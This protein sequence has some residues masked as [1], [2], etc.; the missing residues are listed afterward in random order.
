MTS[1]KK[2]IGLLSGIALG[3]SSI[4]GSGWLFA[5]YQAATIAGPAAIFSWII[6]SIIVSLLGL[7][8]A[9]I[10][11]L[12]PQRGL[13]A[14]IPI[15]SHNRHFAFPFAI[16]NWLGVVA[17]I[18]LE[19]DATNEYLINLVPHLQPYL[20]HA[21]HLTLLGNLFS[22]ALVVLFGVFNYWGA[23]TLVKANNLLTIVKV[24]VPLFIGCAILW[25]SFNPHNF[26]AVKNTMAPYG[27]QS[28]L[29]AILTCGIVVSFNGFQGIVSFA[30]DIKSP[31][32]TIPQAI[33]LSIFFSLL[34]YLVLEFA[35]IGAIPSEA[36]EHGWHALHFYAPVIQVMGFIGLGFLT[37][38]A[39]FGATAAPVGCGI[40]FTGTASRMFTAMA[41]HKQMPSYFGQIHPVYAISRRSLWLNL[42]LSIVFILL[43]N[44]WKN[45]AEVLGLLHV[46]S[47]L[48][49][50]IALW[51]LRSKICD[52]RYGY[53]LPG[54][55][56]IAFLLFLFFSYLF[57]LADFI[58]TL[59]VMAIF[60]VCFIV[61][62]IS[63]SRSRLHFLSIL[64]K[65]W[66]LLL[67]FSAIVTL[68][69]YTPNIGV[70]PTITHL[71]LV[72]SVTILFFI[73][74]I[75]TART[76]IPLMG[77]RLKAIG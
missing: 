54:G 46:I 7:C 15:L 26:V 21:N 56:V 47:Y 2:S 29:T 23:K 68:T 45:L 71:L 72:F 52:K 28:I 3:V 24:C 55:R 66:F 63:V 19:A 59:K 77:I 58:I 33:I 51:A 14:I 41:Q 44:S 40:A 43:F 22:I 64:Q 49:V 6:A 16:A 31:S 10:A 74:F 9:E 70:S 37:S 17:V 39:Y 12:Y 69:A 50:P 27:Y 67:Y 53:H 48:P 36:L 76:D 5:P 32:K 75:K 73:C 1:E 25:T 57:T 34:V 65:I 13:S 60:S 42:V 35:I 62:L 61:Y 18:G 4:L 20:F 30:N 38:V 8:F 11:G